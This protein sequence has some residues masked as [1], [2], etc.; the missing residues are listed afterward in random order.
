VSGSDAQAPLR[1]HNVIAGDSQRRQSLSHT[2]GSVPPLSIRQAHPLIRYL[3]RELPVGHPG[4]CV[5]FTSE[6]RD[7]I[8]R[9]T[10]LRDFDGIVTFALRQDAE[11]YLGHT[12]SMPQIL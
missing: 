5:R 4:L 8:G 10:G 1:E 6:T 11:R 3:A 12:R 2:D 9:V 7:R